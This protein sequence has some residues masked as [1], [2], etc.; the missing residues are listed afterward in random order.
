MQLLKEW[1]K[2]L[3]KSV[4]YDHPSHIRSLYYFKPL[5]RPINFKM[6]VIS[7]FAVIVAFVGAAL[8]P[9]T[10][11][12][13]IAAPVVTNGLHIDNVGYGCLGCDH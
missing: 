6:Q 13:A 12:M 1:D 11:N 9:T 2:Y 3:L 8:V 4:N 7:L 10:N 5:H